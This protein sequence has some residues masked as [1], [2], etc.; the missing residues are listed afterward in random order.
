[1]AAP[2][3]RSRA[4]FGWHVIQFMRPSGDGR[5]RL[6]QRR[7]R[8]TSPTRPT[9]AMPRGTTGEPG[10]GATAATSA[11]SPRASSP[12]SST[13]RSS[14][15]TVGR[16]VERRDG[17][18]RRRPPVLGPRRGDARRRPRSSSRSSRTPASRTGTR[19]QKDA[20]DIDYNLGTSSVRLGERCS[21]PSS[22]RRR[23][24]WGLDVS[25]GLQVVAAERLIATPIEAS[26]PLLDRPARDAAR[27]R[28][29]EPPRG[30]PLRSPLPSRSPGRHGPAGR[31]PLGVLRR[32]YPGD[33]TV[34]RLGAARRPAAAT[35]IGAL[36]R[37]G[38]RRARCTCRRSRRS[39]PRPGRGPCRT[40]AHR[41]RQPDGCPWDREQTHA[42]LRKH[43][44]EETY[45][46]YDALEAGRDAGARRGARR[47]A[48]PGRP[49][50]AA[51]RRGRRVRPRR[52]PGRPSRA[53]SCAATRTSSATRSRGP[54]RTSTGSGSGS[55]PTSGSRPPAPRRRASGDANGTGGTAGVKSALDGISPSLPALA[56]SQEMQERAAALGYDWPDIE[57][58]LDKV[59][60][61]LARARAAPEATASARRSSAT[62]CSSS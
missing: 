60:E 53:R 31:D 18:G 56:A 11:G 29:P 61:E 28:A 59:A 15:T 34:A 55:R 36:D 14:P 8:P 51:R 62:C 7:S 35:T 2:R 25:A 39:W 4:T 58:V 42:S 41:L 17:L 26:R 40:S 37:R 45:E 6:S 47:P 38:P 44:L 20:A 46:V 22:P 19:R 23:D 13:R 16:D 3:R 10:R 48:A 9:S 24:R 33:A 54:P 30:R 5:D 27:D 32:L 21:T 57:G 43:L 49:P 1:M 52:R 50:R 12:T